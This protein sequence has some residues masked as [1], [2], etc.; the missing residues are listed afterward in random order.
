MFPVVNQVADNKIRLQKFLSE[1]GVASRRKA[2]EMIRNGLIKVN[3][4]VAQIGDTVDPKRDTVVIKGKKTLT[5]GN[6]SE[7]G[8]LSYCNEMLSQIILGAFEG[9]ILLGFVSFKES[10]SAIAKQS[11]VFLLGL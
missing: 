4:S 3:G 2:E 5:G 7:Q 8:L 9:D 1:A 11:M 10:S 6:S